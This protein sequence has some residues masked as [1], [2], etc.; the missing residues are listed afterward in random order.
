L[1]AEK[2]SA[3]SIPGGLHKFAADL[4]MGKGKSEITKD[5]VTYINVR[6]WSFV[7]QHKLSGGLIYII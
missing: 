3:E 1:E 4:K 7:H 6:G 5:D 2:A